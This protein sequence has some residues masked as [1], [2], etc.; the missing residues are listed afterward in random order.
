ML[1]F[2]GPL[3]LFATMGPGLLQRSLM[4]FLHRVLGLELCILYTIKELSLCHKFNFCNPYI[5][6]TWWCKPLIF[7]TYIIWSNSIYSLLNIKGLRHW[8]AK[9]LK[10]ENQSLWQR[11]NSQFL[12]N[13]LLVRSLF[14]EFLSFF[15]LL[16]NST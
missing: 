15:I 14:P 3:K 10:L 13:L 16:F 4:V 9:I 11:L 12:F 5:F 8:V 7:K 2:L 6:A 1:K